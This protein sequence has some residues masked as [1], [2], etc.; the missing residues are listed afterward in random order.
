MI[1]NIILECLSD[2]Y[3]LNEGKKFWQSWWSSTK[4]V[5]SSYLIVLKSQ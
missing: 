3:I 2:F 5:S 1:E 4:C